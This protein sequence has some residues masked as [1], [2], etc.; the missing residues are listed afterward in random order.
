MGFYQFRK[1][2]LIHSDI[3]EVWD[4]ISSPFNLKEISGNT[5]LKKMRD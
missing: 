5:G 4:F 2:Q 3:N 1:E